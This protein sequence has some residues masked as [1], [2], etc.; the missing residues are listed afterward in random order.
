MHTKYRCLQLQ[1][2][3]AASAHRRFRSR[4][5][6]RRIRTPIPF[7]F[8]VDSNPSRRQ[9]DPRRKLARRILTHLI[10]LYMLNEDYLA[11]IE[12]TL[13]FCVPRK[14]T[15]ETSPLPRSSPDVGFLIC[16]DPLCFSLWGKP[17]P[18][19]V[20]TSRYVWL[21]V[22]CLVFYIVLD[23]QGPTYIL[24]SFYSYICTP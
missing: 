1:F 24:Y 16:S 7:F 15:A 11:P 19:K 18:I 5:L 4:F 20:C 6:R 3:I 13:A 22:S 21:M 17:G 2:R 10:S 9:L 23:L 8:P 14:I 12:P